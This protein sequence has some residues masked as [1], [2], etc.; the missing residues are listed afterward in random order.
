MHNH[1]HRCFGL[2]SKDSNPPRTDFATIYKSA[3]PRVHPG[4]WPAMRGRGAGT[5]KTFITLVNQNSIVWCC[6][7]DHLF[8][9]VD[10]PYEHPGTHHTHART[11]N[12]SQLP[13]TT[14][15]A[16]NNLKLNIIGT[17]VCTTGTVNDTYA[18]TTAKIIDTYAC[19]ERR[20]KRHIYIYIHTC[21]ERSNKRHTYT[22]T[23]RE[24]HAL[25]P[26]GESSN[27]H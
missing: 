5:H 10:E 13:T 2:S 21:T 17:Y 16:P 24:E 8:E 19:A 26:G 14:P 6:G 15:I 4:G 18:C 23:D 11:H 1:S 27:E 9:T 20:N 7:H 3:E 22:C 25:D 12:I